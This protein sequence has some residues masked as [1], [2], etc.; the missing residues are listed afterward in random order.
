M[1]L[2]MDEIALLMVFHTDWVV[3]FMIFHAVEIIVLNAAKFPVNRALIAASPTLIRSFIAFH[4]VR[5]TVRMV[6]QIVVIIVMIDVMIVEIIVL[7]AVIAVLII[8]LIIDHT[9]VT[10]EITVFHTVVNIVTTTVSAVWIMV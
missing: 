7:T 1:P 5:V 8:V 10:T 3:D 9:V 4:T 2:I 6:F